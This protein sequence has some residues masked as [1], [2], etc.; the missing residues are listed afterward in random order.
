[1]NQSYD[2]IGVGLVAVDI[3][4][5]TPPDARAGEKNNTP[6]LIMQG[7]APAGSGTCGPAML[8]YRAG[9]LA[10]LGDNILS[11]IARDEFAARG[12][13]ADLFVSAPNAEPAFALVQIDPKTAERTV[14]YNLSRYQHLQAADLPV[15]TLRN[16]RALLLDSFEIDATL[17]TLDAVAGASARTILDLEHG[18]HDRIRKAISKATDSIL[19]WGLAKALTG[20]AEPEEALAEL[21]A[22]TKGNLLVTDGVR[23][24]WACD[25]AGIQHQ[26]AFRVAAVDSTGCGDAYHGG[27]IVGV[28]EGWD[29]AKRMEFG[30]WLAAE[31]AQALGGRTNLPSR[32]ELASRNTEMLSPVTRAAVLKLAAKSV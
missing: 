20:K 12:V 28:L 8:G 6:Q 29:L 32:Q 21:R 18:D 27:Y 1:M 2:L 23:G 7:G 3:L 16:A 24:S 14:Y 19:P 26:P 13:S 11:D 10:R 25:G 4:W 5:I 31:V 9:F 17:A 22:L 15:E 30:A